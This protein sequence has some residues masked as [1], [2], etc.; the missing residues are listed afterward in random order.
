MRSATCTIAQPMRV[1]STWPHMHEIGAEF[2]SS[3]ISASGV[4]RP[5]VDVDPWR[6]DVQQVYPVGENLVTGDSIETTC[7]WR[8]DTDEYVFPGP[9]IGNEMCGQSLIVWPYE[10]AGCAN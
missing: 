7:V 2:H 9:G 6:F 4:R 3:I 10:A 8:N 1:L 5:L